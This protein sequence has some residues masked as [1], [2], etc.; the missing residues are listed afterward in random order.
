MPLEIL[1]I[2][3]VAGLSL[4][5]CAVHFSGMSRPA[6]IASE[7]SARARFLIDYPDEE[8]GEIAISD[9]GKAAFIALA[10]G[11][12]GLVHAIGARYITRIL[13]PQSLREVRCDES[14]GLALRL[15]DFTLPAEHAHF[16]SAS[17]AAKV[18]RWLSGAT[19]A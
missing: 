7:E 17:E 1:A 12:T 5:I 16:T 15:R 9:D 13:Q 4:V 10:G 8:I 2:M 14:G 18:S 3:V 11:R 6:R 19:N